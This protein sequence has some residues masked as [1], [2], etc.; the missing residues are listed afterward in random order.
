M[1]RTK[2][3]KD[4]TS[5][6]FLY[7][8]R[9][10]P[11]IT[12]AVGSRIEGKSLPP[13]TRSSFGDWRSSPGCTVEV[14]RSNCGAKSVMS[15][16]EECDEKSKHRDSGGQRRITR[17]GRRILALQKTKGGATAQSLA[18]VESPLIRRVREGT[19]LAPIT[20]FAKAD[21]NGAQR[22][23]SGREP[24]APASAIPP[25]HNTRK[26]PFSVNRP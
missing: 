12:G 21:S 5:R 22:A 6:Q 3:S 14:L 15:V 8:W 1:V 18:E 26:N 20:T 11:A 7:L 23:K 19:R 24:G 25:A 2:Y 9:A 16:R 4:S 13:E 10:L 17:G